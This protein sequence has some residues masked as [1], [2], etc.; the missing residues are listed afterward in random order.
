MF[1]SGS[2]QAV[3]YTAL[4]LDVAVMNTLG[5]LLAEGGCDSGLLSPLRSSATPVKPASIARRRQRAARRLAVESGD[6]TPSAEKKP[7]TTAS[8]SVDPMAASIQATASSANDPMA[9][10][11]QATANSAKLEAQINGLKT[12]LEVLPT[13]SKQHAA[14]TN[15]MVQLC[16]IATEY[17]SA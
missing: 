17:D 3:M 4:V 7:R 1:A 12:L 13:G 14:A 11:I 8:S 6:G 5:R 15:Q 2:G 16:G 10:A 9:A